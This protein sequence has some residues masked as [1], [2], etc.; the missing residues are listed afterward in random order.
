MLAHG[1]DDERTAASRVAVADRNAEAGIGPGERLADGDLAAY[2][3][4][5][6][7]L[8]SRDVDVL[9]RVREELASRDAELLSRRK[10]PQAPPDAL[11]VRSIA[12]DG[13]DQAPVSPHVPGR[14][15]ASPQGDQVFG[16]RVD[17]GA[18][19]RVGADEQRAELD[20]LDRVGLLAGARE[21]RG[22]PGTGVGSV[23]GSDVFGAHGRGPSLARFAPTPLTPIY[24]WL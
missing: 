21:P 4:Q 23:T 3:G 13:G 14:R 6:G 2:V 19:R 24:V 7:E 15:Q 1:D 5:V 16:V 18:D 12:D 17:E 11:A 10:A 8:A 22:H 20:Q 9:S